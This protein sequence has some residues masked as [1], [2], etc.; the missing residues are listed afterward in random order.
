MLKCSQGLCDILLIIMCLRAMDDREKRTVLCKATSYQSNNKA[1]ATMM[2][3]I[4]LNASNCCRRFLC[5]LI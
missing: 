2:V 3:L 4:I 5:L 1:E